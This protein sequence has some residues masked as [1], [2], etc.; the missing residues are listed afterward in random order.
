MD[1]WRHDM[2]KMYQKKGFFDNP[3]KNLEVMGLCYEDK[4]SWQTLSNAMTVP[5]SDD[6]TKFWVELDNF[7]KG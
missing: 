5:R 3:S 4:T 7:K 2:S 1:R 6:Y